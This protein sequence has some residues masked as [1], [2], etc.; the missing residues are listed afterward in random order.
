[1]CKKSSPFRICYHILLLL[2]TI[3]LKVFMSITWKIEV[4]TARISAGARNTGCVSPPRLLARYVPAHHWVLTF[5][6]INT[7]LHI[8]KEKHLFLPH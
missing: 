2:I 3:P 1:M 5:Y 8:C 7:G 4:A 6:M